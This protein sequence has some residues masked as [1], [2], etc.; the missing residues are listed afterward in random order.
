LPST[1]VPPEQVLAA[2]LRHERRRRRALGLP[3]PLH[4]GDLGVAGGDDE[5]DARGAGQPGAQQRRRHR[6]EVAGAQV[7]LGGE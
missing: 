6:G 3:E 4:A 1:L 7:L 5:G 2:A